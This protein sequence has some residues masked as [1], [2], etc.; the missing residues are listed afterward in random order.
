MK[1]EDFTGGR[2]PTQNEQWVAC[3]MANEA[4]EKLIINLVVEFSTYPDPG[5][6]DEPPTAAAIIDRLLGGPANLTDLLNHTDL[7]P[8]GDFDMDVARRVA[9]EMIE[10]HI[11]KVRQVGLGER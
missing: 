1:I 2:K 6:S 9:L 7:K 4:L 8:G 3:A 10:D 5:I 11:K